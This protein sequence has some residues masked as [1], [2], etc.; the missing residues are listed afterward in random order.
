[1]VIL[2]ISSFRP[3]EFF[4]RTNMPMDG[5]ELA[6]M[7]ANGP[8]F[9]VSLVLFIGL[10]YLC[11]RSL[12]FVKES[13]LFLFGTLFYLALGAYVILHQNDVLRHDALA[14]LEAAKALNRGDYSILTEVSGYLHKYPHQLGL[15]SFERLILTLFGESNVKV[16]FIINLVM[17]IAD[18]FFLWKITQNLFKKDNISKIVLLLSFVF[19]PH[20][21]NILFV[22]GLTYGLFFALIGLY[23]L[24]LYFDKKSWSNLLLSTVFLSLS[25]IIRNNYII[26]IITVLIVLMLDFLYHKTK[27]NLAFMVILLASIIAGNRAISSYYQ[28]VARVD[29]LDGE[30]KV[31]WIAMGLNDTPI[32]NRVAGWYDAYVET[33][34]NEHQGDAEAIEE[35][36][37]RQIVSRVTYMVKHPDYAWNFFK[38]KFLSTWTDSLF[39]SIWS[40]PVTK[41]P[42][43]GQKITGRLMT[44]I[45]QGKLAYQIIYYFSALLLVVI[46]VSVLPS[47]WTQYRQKDGMI[48]FLLIPLIYLTGGFIFHLIW[49]TKSQYVYPYV[50]LLLPLSALGLD[51]MMTLVIKKE[52]MMI[53]MTK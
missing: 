9:F 51:Y 28:Q 30:P 24:Q 53:K 23:F 10:L 21:F 49:E 40:G 34:Y 1:M 38:N 37:E 42:V 31:A 44:S 39:E 41:M 52:D 4:V 12:A 43:E 50:Y 32:Y 3:I 25:D 20:L 48:V 7:Q 22:Y 13:Y 29:H 27:K 11:L 14:V 36:S 33:V 26:L 6:N 17:A 18:N 8:I 5:S 35:A 47:I 19:L 15:V 2:A 46:Y 16:F 45:Y